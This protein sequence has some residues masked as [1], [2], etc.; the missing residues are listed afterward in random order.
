M[1][2]EKKFFKRK[3]VIQYDTHGNEKG[4]FISVSDASRDTDINRTNINHC[5][6]GKQKMAGGF[7]W[8]YDGK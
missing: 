8:E 5:L 2:N 1:A 3:P 7:V 4:K 6:R